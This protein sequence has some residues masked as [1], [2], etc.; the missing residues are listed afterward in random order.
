MMWLMLLYGG[1]DAYTSWI[2]GKARRERPSPSEA[3]R[4]PRKPGECENLG[5]VSEYLISEELELTMK[6][7]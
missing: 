5:I 6:R 2:N 3:L 1:S 4:L 7:L